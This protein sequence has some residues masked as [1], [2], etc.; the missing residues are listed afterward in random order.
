MSTV[1]KT[2]RLEKGKALVL[3]GP[4]GCGKSTLARQIASGLGRFIETDASILN[5]EW[6]TLAVL[7]SRP[8]VLIID[9]LPR[10]IAATARAKA[11][12]S[13]PLVRMSGR[14]GQ[15]MA[16]KPPHLIFCTGEAD[17]LNGSGDRRFSVFRMDAAQK[18]CAA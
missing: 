6:G 1:T 2:P 9:G 16:I 3:V 7:Q 11:L 4:E 14:N 5:S 17:C 12:I 13:N 10:G 18:A 15:D 8:D